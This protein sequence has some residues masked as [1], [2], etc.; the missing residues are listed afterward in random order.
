MKNKSA[1]I[2]A[3]AL[4]LTIFAGCR[5]KQK[6][7]I[8]V[9]IDSKQVSYLEAYCLSL[10]P[11]TVRMEDDPALVLALIEMFNGEYSYYDTLEIPIIFSAGDP[12]TVI[13]YDN[14]RNEI[15]KLSFMDDELY[16]VHKNGKSDARSYDRYK[17][18]EHPLDFASFY[19]AVYGYVEDVSTNPPAI[20]LD[21]HSILHAPVSE[22]VIIMEG[23]ENQITDSETI[24]EV[25]SALEHTELCLSENED[26][27]APGAVSVSIG[28][29]TGSDTVTITLPCFLYEGHVYRAD[30]ASIE[31]FGKYID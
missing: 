19:Q 30:A 23:K 13:F 31:P 26:L 7:S 5:S 21:I 9:Q 6:S 28:V 10:G 11:R 8:T 12:Y 17:H 25:V 14:S 16:V 3:F 29:M 4:C 1:I 18:T 15:I 24:N 2:L 27:N 20:P 22:V